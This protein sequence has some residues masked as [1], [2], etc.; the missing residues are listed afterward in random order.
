MHTLQQQVQQLAQQLEEDAASQAL[1]A[2]ASLLAD[3]QVADQSVRC[4]A[5]A[6]C[7]SCQLGT[8]VESTK[9]H[10]RLA[11]NTVMQSIVGLLP[12]M[13]LAS[14]AEKFSVS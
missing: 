1:E 11:T 5:V 10:A 3:R 4:D 12:I 2:Q 7:L 13:T 8:V 9:M 6:C 14:D